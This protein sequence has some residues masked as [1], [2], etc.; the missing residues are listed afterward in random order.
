MAKSCGPSPVR[1]ICGLEERFA[2]S[3]RLPSARVFGWQ[4]ADKNLR[5]TVGKTAPQLH[6]VCAWWRCHSLHFQS[7]LCFIQI[8]YPL[9]YVSLENI[10]ID[11]E[12]RNN[13]TWNVS[14]S[15]CAN[16]VFSLKQL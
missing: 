9:S 2:S 16:S 13:K 6:R 10:Y 11:N 8:Q 4:L 3:S 15:V 5:S 1:S 14:Y 7:C 12:K